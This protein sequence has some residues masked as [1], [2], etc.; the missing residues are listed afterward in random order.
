MCR[1]RDTGSK[2]CRWVHQPDSFHYNQRQLVKLDR[3]RSRA[4]LSAYVSEED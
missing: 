4:A 2:V 3:R 1:C